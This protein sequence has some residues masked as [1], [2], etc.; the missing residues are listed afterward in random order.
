[1]PKEKAAVPVPSVLDTAS[2]TAITLTLSCATAKADIY[3]SIDTPITSTYNGI[4]Y[5]S[6]TKITLKRVDNQVVTYKLYTYAKSND[7]RIDDSLVKT[8]TYTVGKDYGV[9]SIEIVKRPAKYSYYMGE[10]LNVVGGLIKVTYIDETKAPETVYMTESMIQDF[11]SWVLGQ[12]TLTVYYQ[13]CTAAFNIVVRR[14]SSSSSDSDNKPSDSGKD[15]GKKDD[16]TTDP[17]T[18]DTDKDNTTDGTVSDP[19]MVGS[20]VK[21]WTQ[22]QKKIA[23]AAKN[24]RIGWSGLRFL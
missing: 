17:G 4:L 5:K 18:S 23:A 22:L 15:D 2:E 21:G 20:L 16:T 12:Q 9:K 10:K 19:T 6:G 3:Y 14:R 13:G 7:P 8:Y 24:S 1:M 11:D